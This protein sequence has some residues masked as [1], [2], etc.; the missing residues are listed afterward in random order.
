M[1]WIKKLFGKSNTIT[2]VPSGT[3]SFTLTQSQQNR[4]NELWKEFGAM[5]YCFYP[6][7]GVGYGFKVKIWKTGEFI[8]LTNE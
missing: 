3:Q 7:E 6:C 8:D 2:V 4:V 5:D 1:N